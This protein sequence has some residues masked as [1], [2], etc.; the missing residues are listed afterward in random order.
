MEKEEVTVKEFYVTI[1]VT[2]MHG[3]CAILV[4]NDSGTTT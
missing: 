4:I 2:N 3:T 1:A